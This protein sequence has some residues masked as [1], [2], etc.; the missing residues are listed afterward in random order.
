MGEIIMRQFNVR[1]DIEITIPE[2]ERQYQ[3][4]IRPMDNDRSSQLLSEGRL[5]AVEGEHDNVYRLFD[6]LC[7]RA[8]SDTQKIKSC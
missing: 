5:I 4:K 7:P 1:K 8:L 6:R 2:A 3:V